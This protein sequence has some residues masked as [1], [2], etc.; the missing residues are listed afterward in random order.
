MIET[1]QKILAAFGMPLHDISSS[2]CHSEE[3][4]ATKNLFLIRLS[5]SRNSTISDKGLRGRGAGVS[6]P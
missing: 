2:F 6:L 1:L 5:Y 4:K 3:G